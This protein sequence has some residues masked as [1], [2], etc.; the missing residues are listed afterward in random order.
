MKEHSWPMR[1][2]V[3][4]FNININLSLREW[5]MTEE[6]T[7]EMTAKEKNKNKEKGNK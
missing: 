4:Q 6:N 3:K 1:Q 5:I 7:W 2:Y